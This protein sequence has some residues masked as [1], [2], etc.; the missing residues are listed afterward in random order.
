MI[1]RSLR[2]AAI[3]AVLNQ[4]LTLR[5][6][7][8]DIAWQSF[9]FVRQSLSR[10]RSDLDLCQALIAPEIACGEIP[11]RITPGLASEP[12]HTPLDALAM[13]IKQTFAWI[14]HKMLAVFGGGC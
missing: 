5:E 3:K 14:A 10:P 11:M 6:K 7:I 8:W 1:G 12:D 4:I 9:G 13:I 2:D